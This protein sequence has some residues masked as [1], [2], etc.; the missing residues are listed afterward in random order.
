MIDYR[1]EWYGKYKTLEHYQ[2]FDTRDMTFWEMSYGDRFLEIARLM[3][4]EKLMDGMTLLDIGCGT[5]RAME[6]FS[7]HRIDC[8]GVEPSREASGVAMVKGFKV[9]PCKIEEVETRIT[10]DI[11]NI[12]QVLSHMPN[13]KEALSKARE[14]LNDDGILIVEEPNDYNPLQLKVGKG[15]YWVTEDHAN[16]FNYKTMRE[17]LNE[18]GFEVIYITCTYPMELFE[19]SGREYIG[20]DKA[21]AWFHKEAAELL[22]RMGYE[23]R[24]ELLE[25][26]AEIGIGRDLVMLA[27]KTGKKGVSDGQ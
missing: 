9:F 18:A 1:T 26:Y 4:T 7:K 8:T 14:L 16:Y 15:P 25:K 19:L 22:N 3:P 10:Y 27:R 6:H 23:L 21:G 5:G 2:D 12:E 24:R 13:Y 20:D 11:I 17:A